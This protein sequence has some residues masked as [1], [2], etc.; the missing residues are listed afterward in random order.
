MKFRKRMSPIIKVFDG[1]AY[2]AVEWFHQPRPAKAAQTRAAIQGF[3]TRL[4]FEPDWPGYFLY[5]SN[6]QVLGGTQ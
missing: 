4:V 6:G 3:I 1:V 2:E 5:V